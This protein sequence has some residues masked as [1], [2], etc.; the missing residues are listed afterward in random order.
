M[1]RQSLLTLCGVMGEG[2]VPVLFRALCDCPTRSVRQELCDLL[3]ALKQATRRFLAAE[4]EKK[5]IPWYFQ[6]NLVNLLGRVGDESELPLVSRFL[7]DKHPRV[8]LEAILTACALDASG[9]ERT[10]IGGLA[11][12][13]ADIRAV[14]LRQLVQRRSTAIELFDHLSALL[15]GLQPGESEAALQACGLLASY[16][17]G[18][19]YERAVDVLLA[20]LKDEPRRGFWSRLAGGPTA[21]HSLKVAACQTLGRLRARR[22]VPE[23]AR[24]AEGGPRTLKPAATL[25]LRQIQVASDARGERPTRPPIP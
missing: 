24:L 23:L 18:E 8:R 4:L 25:A 22:A 3:E 5:A 14:C 17:S 21:Q 10:L 15:E 9:A 11:D 6:R 7:A 16:Q 2:G 12:Q 1:R 13:D 20:V 19:G